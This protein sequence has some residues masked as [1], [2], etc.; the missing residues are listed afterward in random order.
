MVLYN[1]L[2]TDSFFS[3]VPVDKVADFCRRWKIQE[4]ALFGSALRENFRA[5]SDLDF[6]ATFAADADWSLLDHVQMQLELERLFHRPVDLISRR[7]LEQSHN[8]LLREEILGTARILFQ[9]H[10]ATRAAR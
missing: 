8:R 3:T 4:L 9:T 7:A 6:M 5:D 10:E 1:A 2:V